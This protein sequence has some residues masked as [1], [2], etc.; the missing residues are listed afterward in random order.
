[1]TEHM[2]T[3]KLVMG[4][5]EVMGPDG[6]DGIPYDEAVIH[7][8]GDEDSEIEVHCP[9]ALRLA[10]FI[11][12]AVNNHDAL[13]KALEEIQDLGADG[14]TAARLGNIAHAAL[15]AIRLNGD[16]SSDRGTAPN[17]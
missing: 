2:P 1:M 12:K 9:G 3:A 14:A 13:V 17:D 6:S 16:V 5:I 4:Y 10:P 7:L 15:I 11:V 8:E